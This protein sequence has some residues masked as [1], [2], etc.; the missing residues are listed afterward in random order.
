MTGAS[1]GVG[2]E[3]SKILYSKGATVYIA[4]RS[5]EKLD[6][7]KQGILSAVTQSGGKLETLQ[8]D[9]ADLTTI[10]R[11]AEEFLSKEATLNVVV[12]NAGVMRPPPGS[13]TKQV[14]DSIRLQF[15]ADR[16]QGFDLEMGTNCLGPFL[17]NRLLIDTMLRTVQYKRGAGVT[18]DQAAGRIVWTSSNVNRIAPKEAIDWDPKTGH[19][20]IHE[21]PMTNYGQSKAGDVLMATEAARKYGPDGIISVSL[22]PGLIRT[23]LQREMGATTRRFANATVFKDPKFGAYTELFAGFSPEVTL[24]KNGCWI[25]PWGRIEPLDKGMVRASRT[26]EEGGSGVA[27]KFWRYCEQQTSMFM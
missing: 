8:L 24:Q 5:Q 6:K 12:H 25:M 11:S 17:F 16:Q 21:D 19:P 22:H 13:R 1:S 26:P 7:A 15:P 2:Y 20:K 14:R 3:L 9:L 27:Q 18:A 23:E 10:K 4:A